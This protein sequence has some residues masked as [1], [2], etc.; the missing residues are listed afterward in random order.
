MPKRH[1][2]PKE[3][4]SLFPGDSPEL[5][6]GSIIAGVQSAK[7]INMSSCRFERSAPPPRDVVVLVTVITQAQTIASAPTRFGTTLTYFVHGRDGSRIATAGW[8]AA[9]GNRNGR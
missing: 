1:E 2:T 4:S 6:N 8:R 9:A 7:E 5:F 3:R